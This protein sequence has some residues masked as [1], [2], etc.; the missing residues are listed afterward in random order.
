MTMKIPKITKLPSGNY[1]CQLRLGGKSVSVTGETKRDVEIQATLL[2]SNYRANKPV[3]A[4]TSLS[5]RDAI[6]KYIK[7]RKK[8]H[9]PSTIRGY[10][11][12]ADNRFQKYMD[13]DIYDSRTDW[14]KMVQD[15]MGEVS[16]KTLKNAWS[17]VC[18]VLKDN[19]STHRRLLSSKT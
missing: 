10:R 6:E 17:L 9:S 16:R 18:S 15:E 12:I 5:L 2:K 4:K 8:D 19:G 13:K 3:Y 11:V 7:D 1:F 14:K